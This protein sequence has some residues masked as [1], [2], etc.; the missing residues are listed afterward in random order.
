MNIL[1]TGGLGFIGS[2]VAQT[3]KRLNIFPLLLDSVYNYGGIPKDEFDNLYAHRLE[4][5]KDCT[6]IDN[7]IINKD[8]LL[9]IFNSYK[10][11]LVI[12]CASPSRQKAF[13]SDMPWSSR[14]MAE[15]LLNI[16]DASV[17]NNVKKIVYI[18][19]S[20]VYGNFS[21]FV[22]ETQIC[23]PLNEYGV[24]KLAGENLVRHYTRL[25]DLP[26]VILRPSAV[27]GPSD[28]SDRVIS[29]FFSCAF[30]NSQLLINGANE[31]L[32]FSYVT[33]IA[34]GI[35]KASLCNVKNE[36]YNISKGE[37]FSLTEA[38]NIIIDIVKSG[39]ISIAEKDK[40]MPSR[41]ALS[42]IKAQR[43]F[44]YNPQVS[45]WQGIRK[46]YEWLCDTSFRTAKT[47]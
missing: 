30:N 47:I 24:F 19:S 18:S 26:H 4:I 16:L 42:I 13:L 46:Q 29:K 9:S 44:G 5:H 33:D 21:D 41:G 22:Q 12:H 15:G 6:I 20:M 17:K 45:L 10:P 34:E 14:T 38:A 23:N 3:L 35:V 43:D 40:N 8:H 27:Y 31:R 28:Y 1:I 2:N 7:N 36:T 37:S 25:Y 32:D 11:D 39:T